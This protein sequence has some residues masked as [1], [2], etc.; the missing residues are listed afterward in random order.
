MIPEYISFCLTG[1]MKNEYT[2]ATTG[3]TVN[4]ET[5]KRDNELLELLGIRTDIFEEYGYEYVNN[6]LKK[7]SLF[8]NKEILGY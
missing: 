7:K 3:A 5:K 1:V 8:Y 2:N 4:A 6:E